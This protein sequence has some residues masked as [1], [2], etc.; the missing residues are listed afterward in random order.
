M[1]LEQTPT[2][3]RRY[4]HASAYILG[5][6]GASPKML[7]FIAH[8]DGC[9]EI[10]KQLQIAIRKHHPKWNLDEIYYRGVDLA[11][12]IEDADTTGD[13]SSEM[14]VMRNI[15]NVVKHSPRLVVLAHAVGKKYIQT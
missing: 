10:F 3:M 9:D 1:N 11:E 2:I 15:V 6:Y 8:L 5:V 14:L 7:F 13:G 12:V 4:P